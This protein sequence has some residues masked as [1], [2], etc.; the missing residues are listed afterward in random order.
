MEFCTECAQMAESRIEREPGKRIITWSCL[1]CDATGNRVESPK[2]E[3][4]DSQT[5][6]SGN[7]FSD[8]SMEEP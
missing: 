1:S 3:T 6:D 5:P 8:F 4:V 7:R 2:F